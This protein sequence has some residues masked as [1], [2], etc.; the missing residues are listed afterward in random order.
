M[1]ADAG[2]LQQTVRSKSSH[3]E[4][5][6][7]G[8]IQIVVR[9]R[10]DKE[11]ESTRFRDKL[12]LFLPNSHQASQHVHLI[13]VLIVV[14]VNALLFRLLHSSSH[15]IEQS[16]ASRESFGAEQSKARIREESTRSEAVS[17]ATCVTSTLVY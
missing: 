14:L 16:G 17:D 13:V 9:L 15:S 7:A 12:L 4:L 6:L 10:A 8:C 5:H 11:R 1:E 2:E 3:V